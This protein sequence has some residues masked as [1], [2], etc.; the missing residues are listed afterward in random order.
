[1]LAD[2]HDGA[3]VVGQYGGGGGHQLHR[4]EQSSRD[5][6]ELLV[7]AGR[8]HVEDDG[9]QGQEALGLLGRDVL[10]RARA[11]VYSDRERGHDGPDDTGPRAEVGVRGITAASA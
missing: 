1:M 8:P 2:D 6:A 4:Q 11:A 3:A 7:L 10:V 9:A 5:V